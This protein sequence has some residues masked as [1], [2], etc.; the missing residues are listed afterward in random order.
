VAEL[1]TALGYANNAL[2]AALALVCLVAWR[3]RGG[4]ALGWLAATFGVIAAVVLEGLLVP[5]DLHGSLEWVQKLSVATVLLFPYFLYRFMTAMRGPARRMDLAAASL[6]AVVV[7]W[8][9]ALPRVPGPD[10]PRPGWYGLFIGA[11]LVQWSVLSL[12][13][14]VKLWTAGR[15]E[16]VA[17][18]RRMQLLSA[19]SVGLDVAIILSGSAPSHG[20]GV[21]V[22]TQILAL[23]SLV[24]F[25]SGYSSPR[26]LRG[27]RR[28]EEEALAGA[29]SELMSATR[30]EEV[31]AH[32]LPRIVNIVGGKGAALLD[33]DGREIGAFGAASTSE[34]PHVEEEG[35]EGARLERLELSSGALLVWTSPYT[36]FFGRD[37]FELFRAL[38]TLAELALERVRAGE[39]DAQLATI[40]ESSS[41]GIIGVDFDGCVTSWNP[42]AEAIFGHAA[43]DAIGRP[44]TIISPPGEDALS[45]ALA[46][47]RAGE[48]VHLHDIRAQRAGRGCVD[49]SIT[50][51]PVTG[52]DGNVTGASVIVRDLT[53]EKA[54]ERARREAE[55]RY[56]S[57]F[58]NAVVGIFETDAQARVISA[59]PAL[60]DVLGFDHPEQLMENLS[61]AWAL[62]SDASRGD[63]L[64]RL[65]D[66]RGIV[67]G[68]EI[69]GRRRDGTAFI[70][71]LDVRTVL[72][73]RGEVRGRQGALVDI[74]DRKRAEVSYLQAK[75]EAESA[76]RA[77]SEF[78][79]RMSHE[80]RTP[81]NA[82]L[83]F[84]Q[85]LEME[86]LSERQEES[87]GHIVKAGRH[88][89][90][91]INE[92]LDIAR[93][94]VGKLSVSM[95][96]VQVSAV[97]SDALDLV[98]PMADGLEVTLDSEAAHTREHVR[99]DGQRLKQV[100]LNLLS[101]GIKYN[102]AGGTVTL[103]C[104]RLGD[105]ALRITVSDDGPGI[106]ADKLD[107]LFTPFER[108][109]AEQGATEGTGL[110]LALSHALVEAMGGTMGVD[111]EP[112]RGSAFWVDLPLVE[113]PIERLEQSEEWEALNDG[114][115]RAPS[116]VL[117]IEDNVSNL[118]LIQ[119]ILAHRPEI[120]LVAAAQGRLGVD[121]ARQH[122]PNL[123]F[124]DLHLPDI[125]GDE[126]FSRLRDLPETND[127][128]VVI[129]SADATEGHI[130]RLL[131][132][133]A[134][135]YLT[136]PLDVRQFLDVLD[137]VLTAVEA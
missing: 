13:V 59:N 16:P 121:M 63:E 57:I 105:E 94:E 24:A 58:E 33:R 129:V 127:I 49:V 126:A 123:I 117:Y 41:D 68:F 136:K 86:E 91:L 14:A 107:Q 108:L 3:R 67:T 66:E 25:F 83:G 4:R 135:A 18:R 6:T 122:R 62:A 40:V 112:G 75:E 28:K 12:V 130:R 119:R 55:E 11:V 93:I 71:L 32:L 2:L 69:E 106:P 23:V 124:L 81:L 30:A 51:S 101:N 50:A 5:D 78:L 38:G 96:S 36:P 34:H 20:P 84:G 7:A 72:D 116:T 35:I 131:D 77:K 46:R 42:G 29:T 120:D 70:A 47:V 8:T 43:G 125:S 48:R 31:T 56:R 9:L 52:S 98:R 22:V 97:V 111:T 95:E 110:G 61:D 73:E 26:M 45:N 88:L 19:G 109:G 113:G 53:E 80:L 87:V 10:D 82:I 74:T 39:K 60:A 54:D 64:R 103:S 89:L 1:A 65:L 99:A 134:H 102:S 92:V 133:G 37:E 85:L 128:P 90:D 21:Q 79:S 15:A 114:L 118:R 76:N 100:L 132:A 115:E 137:G 44:L 104:R 17:A 27:G